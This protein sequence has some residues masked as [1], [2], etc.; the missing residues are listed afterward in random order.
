MLRLKSLF[1]VLFL[2]VISPV[3]LSKSNTDIGKEMYEK[4]IVET[5]IYS[6]TKMADY[7]RRVGNNII[8]I[9]DEPDQEFTF[10]ILDNPDVNA[11]ATPGGYIYI[12]RGLINF[13]QTEAQLAAVLAHEVAHVTESHSSRQQNAS[14]AN[15]AMAGVLWV[16]TGSGDVAEAS[17]MWGATMVSGYG[18]DMELEADEV[19]ALYL[20]RAN[21]DPDAMMQVISILKDNEKFERR[22]SQESGNQTQNY[23]GLFASHPKNDKRLQEVIKKAGSLPANRAA[24]DNTT[25]FR[26]ATDGLVWGENFAA[27]SRKENRFYQEKLRFRFDYP[28][29]WKFKEI[30]NT[31]VGNHA[32]EMGS[33]L[34]MVIEILPRSKESPEHYIKNRLKIPFLKKSEAF[35]QARMPGYSGYIPGDNEKPDQRLALIYYSRYAYAFRGE[36]N[37]SASSTTDDIKIDYDVFTNIIKSF[38]PLSKQ[39]LITKKPKTIDYVKAK[40]GLTFKRLASHLKLGKYGEQELRLI[41]NQYPVGEPKSGEWIKI[42]R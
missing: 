26:I 34:S 11:F 19:G 15:S 29:G 38:R 3:V 12:N 23:H 6:E 1:I 27:M 10:T 4:I 24:I 30:A 36:V 5:P 20:H 2:F 18:R 9:C 14:M 42:V 7:V 32:N 21:Y 25:P 28:E 8:R 31:I 16:L 13:L 33:Q 41:N 40:K 39:E 17:S 37:P 35:T 22:R